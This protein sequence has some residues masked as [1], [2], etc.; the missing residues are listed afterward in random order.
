MA[1]TREAYVQAMHV[2][3]DHSR[4]RDWAAASEAFRRAT[5]ES[6]DDAAAAL[7][8]GSSLLELGQLPIALG[9]LERAAQLL[10]QD[11]RMLGGLADAQQRLGM[12]EAAAATCHQMGSVASR[13]G[14]LQAAADALMRATR[15]A[16]Q[17]AEPHRLLANTLERLARPVQAAAEYAT[18]ASIHEGGSNTGLAVEFYR[19]ALRLDPGNSHLHAGLS[20]LQSSLASGAI[21]LRPPEVAGTVDADA[22]AGAPFAF[23]TRTRET[24]DMLDGP[25]NSLSSHLPG[26]P[27]RMNL[28][29]QARRR[30]LQEMA[31]TFFASVEPGDVLTPAVANAINRAIDQQ[32]RGQTDQA[33]QSWCTAVD[34]GFNRAALLFNLGVLYHEAQ[35]FDKAI[36]AFQQCVSDED[37]GLGAHY[38]LGVVYEAAGA[39]DR[40]LEHFIELVKAVDLQTASA[41]QI[42]WMTLAYQR[43]TDNREGVS[44]RDGDKT[45]AYIRTV[46]EFFLKPSWE[47]RVRQARRDMDRLADAEDGGPMTLAEYLESPDREVAVTSLAA[48]D[49]FVRRHM[50]ATAMEECLHAI[51]KAPHELP[52]HVRVAD[53]QALQERQDQA[54]STYMSVAEAYE[55]RGQ[56]R[57]GADTLRRLLRR[58]PMAM[59]ARSRLI[60]LL[61][62][63]DDIE[64]ALEQVLALADD[65]YQLADLNRALEQ[66]QEALRLVWTSPNRD[67]W[68]IRV[69][70]RMGDIFVQRVDW[71]RATSAYEA[72]VALAP[73]DE[74]A[75]LQLIDLH[76]KQGQGE[77]ALVT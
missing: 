54:V 12:L 24:D 56:L 73:D 8:L 35:H 29:E 13:Q 1:G 23:G 33:I 28:F 30:A 48:S 19:E 36:A 2:A 17:Q 15:L 18:L 67:Q 38:G 27:L 46:K 69:M 65:Y 49:E 42:D 71:V 75:C 51:D 45:N 70:H 61:L 14:D 63:Q 40:A 22:D 20:A 37:L 7:G 52:L 66:Y 31:Q 57:Q 59:E 72:I 21:S 58:V 10:P 77:K 6:P 9:V 5:A 47:S 3:I 39:L 11:A 4:K 43:L 44:I 68:E 74:R 64:Q 26:G 34:G 53:I 60:R 62:C 32:T 76:Y 41:D 25:D 50:L 55:L 16:P